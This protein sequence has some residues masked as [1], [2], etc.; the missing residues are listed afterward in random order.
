MTKTG[1]KTNGK[2]Q[3]KAPLQRGRPGRKPGGNTAAHKTAAGNDPGPAGQGHADL[4]KPGRGS[5]KSPKA[6]PGQPAADHVGGKPA[7]AGRQ[8]KAGSASA[9]GG[10]KNAKEPERPE[11][12]AVNQRKDGKPTRAELKAARKKLVA[13]GEGR[14]KRD[15][16]KTLLEQLQWEADQE[17]LDELPESIPKK[18]PQ[19]NP[20]KYTREM[21]AR[22]LSEIA[23]GRHPTAVCRDEGMISYMTLLAYCAV[24]PEIAAALT[25]AL[26]SFAAHLEGDCLAIAD[27]GANDTYETDNGTRTNVDVIQRSKLRIEVRQRMQTVADSGRYA[28][29]VLM[30]ND[31]TNPLPS[32]KKGLHEYTTDELV[33]A[34]AAAQA[35]QKLT[36][37]EA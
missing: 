36:N 1:A 37:P 27:Y 29:R 28:P 13:E 21:M 10:R 6:D 35:A 34:I 15:K 19:G 26:A 4:G 30:G 33:Q 22:L 12:A 3:R 20:P 17:M 5:S 23:G 2:T 31:P 7:P 11:Q 18:G 24:S 14:F 25:R 16:P 9:A 8:A 32:H